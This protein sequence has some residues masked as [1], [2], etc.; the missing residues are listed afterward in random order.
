MHIS[1]STKP[2]RAFTLIELLV[3]VAIIAGLIAIL[4]PAVQSAREAARRV[5]CLNNM[6]QIVLALYNYHEAMNTFPPGY[7]SLTEDDAPDGAEIGP[8]WGW[9]SMAL[10]QMEQASTY[11]NVNFGLSTSDPAAMTARATRINTLLCPSNPGVDGPLTIRDDA[12]NVL[13]SDLAPSQYVGVAGRLDPQA[14]P[15]ENDG[16][17]YRNSRIGVRDVTDGTSSTLMVGERSQNVANATWVG[18][19]PGGLACNNPSWP[20]QDCEASNALIL[21]HT[22]PAPDDPRIDV[23]NDPRAGVGAFHSRHPG[24]CNFAFCDGSI[25]FIKQTI[26]P[27]VFSDLA[28]RAGGEVISDDAF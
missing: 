11:R 22:G 28:T 12:G 19:I 20:V 4:L 17:F 10:S 7:V 8:G 14:F 9:M 23:P 13:V 6:K 2:R 18:M 16:I 1:G 24:G 15:A 27:Q 5:Q 21:G 3:V 26:R 25:R